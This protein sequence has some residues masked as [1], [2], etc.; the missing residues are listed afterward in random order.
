M[1]ATKKNKLIPVPMSDGLIEFLRENLPAMGYSNRSEFIRDAI[2]EKIRAEE[3]RSGVVLIA[4]D[5]KWSRKGS[6]WPIVANL[7]GRLRDGEK[8]FGGDPNRQSVADL[9]GGLGD[10]K[11]VE[12]ASLAEDSATPYKVAQPTD[13]LATQVGKAALKTGSGPKRKAR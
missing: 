12:A 13:S 6:N 5:S 1:S 2:L 9:S 10:V 8:A 7:S 4:L 11:R 3:K